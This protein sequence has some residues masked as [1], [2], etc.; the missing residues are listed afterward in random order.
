MNDKFS[1]I[2][3]GDSLMVAPFPENYSEE[4][5]E[6]ADFIK[7]CDAKLTNLETNFSD[8][9]YYANAYSGGT[10]LN[11]R[12]ECVNLLKKYGFDY[13]GTANNHAMDY[14][15][16]GLLSTIKTLDD[17]GLYHSGS[18]ESLEIADKP[19][20]FIRNGKKVAVFAVDMSFNKASKAGRA[21]NNIKA[22]PGVSY[23]RVNTYWHV[24]PTQLDQ[25]K[26]IAEESKLNF[27]HN[28][29]VNTG[30][31]NP[32][33]EG[34]LYFGGITFTT[35]KEVPSSSC[36]K[37]DLERIL[38]GIRKAKQENDYVFILTHC[39]DNDGVSHANPPQYL[40][41]FSKAAIDAGVSAVFG[42]GCHQLRGVEIYKNCPIFY[43]LGDFIYQGLKVEHLPADFMEQFNA[44]IY[45]SAIDA[46]YVRSR[47]NKVGL[48]L[49]R[50]NYLTV[51]PKIE[52]ANGKMTKLILKPVSLNFERKDDT[53]GLP[54]LAKGE[55]G[56]E[57][58]SIINN[59]SKKY[60]VQ[61]VFDNEEYVLKV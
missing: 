12:R 26:I 23:V 3:T 27:T 31:A 54:K 59:L 30:F 43:S 55:E 61:F 45:M 17:N 32:D 7:S 38:S 46:L 24:T 13:C 25:L 36:N 39:H 44:D 29:S 33:A 21:T 8:F 6:I 42:G 57:I 1:V 47:G 18:G 15:H 4:Y 16:N 51:L 10:W 41:E 40:E 37:V 49:N 20:L 53:N 14:G 60:N 48:H 52:F 22:R 35:N 50:E 11:T 2:G 28:L 34:M 19:A 5:K 58:I 9:E 56:A